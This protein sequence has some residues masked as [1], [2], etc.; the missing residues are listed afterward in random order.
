M[1]LALRS[2]TTAIMAGE[3]FIDALA[4][5][6]VPKPPAAAD[7]VASVVKVPS[8]YRVRTYGPPVTSTAAAS[9]ESGP[10]SDC[11]SE[12]EGGAPTAAATLTRSGVA[13]PV[14]SDVPGKAMATGT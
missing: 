1:L 6:L 12:P 10:A 4:G 13:G 2:P 11:K 14:D 8:A 9:S 3:D 7:N 5:S